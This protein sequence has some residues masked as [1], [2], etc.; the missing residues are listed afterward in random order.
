MYISRTFKP[1]VSAIETKQNVQKLLLLF[2]I[3]NWH[4]RYR[5]SR[6]LWSQFQNRPTLLNILHAVRGYG[7]GGGGEGEEHQAAGASGQ[8]PAHHHP[9]GPT[10]TPHLLHCQVHLTF[11]GNLPFLNVW[12]K[13]RK[14]GG[15]FYCWQ[16]TT[17]CK[18]K[19]NIFTKFVF[20]CTFF[21]F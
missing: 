14:E 3:L 10:A 12:K 13:Y 11:T 2:Y 9:A 1:P 8:Q 4:I 15:L 17:C 18:R 21:T 6:I 19:K 16:S 20:F 5:I 7:G